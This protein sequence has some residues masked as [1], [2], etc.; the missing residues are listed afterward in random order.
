MFGYNFHLYHELI[1]NLK[2]FS[3]EAN[4]STI[5]DVSA[6]LKQR[7]VRG[8]LVDVFSAASRSDL[9]LQSD[10]IAKKFIKYPS[11]YGFVLSGD[12]QNAA[13]EFRNYL[14]SQADNI[15]KFMKER[16]AGLKVLVFY[17][18]FLELF[19][20]L[21]HIPSLLVSEQIYFVPLKKSELACQK[22]QE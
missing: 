14:S 16:T 8:A 10:I 12:M 9:F 19:A 17:S 6:A 7:Q 18:V 13:P 15:L 21:T 20:D 2:F 3:T 22:W 1:A 4:Y 11:A 5:E